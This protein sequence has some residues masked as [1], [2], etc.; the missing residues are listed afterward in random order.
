MVTLAEAVHNTRPA[1]LSSAGCLNQTVYPK[2]AVQHAGSLFT[3]VSVCVWAF[4]G[5]P[6]PDMH[7]AARQGG[8]ALW[9]PPRSA[10]V[11][12]GA[13]PT[14]RAG[15]S[16]RFNIPPLKA[17]LRRAPATPTRSSARS[18]RQPAGGSRSS[19]SVCSRS[20]G[21]PARATSRRKARGRRSTGRKVRQAGAPGGRCGWR[22]T[23]RKVR[24]QGSEGSDEATG[25]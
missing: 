5:L 18:S 16:L 8:D 25:S 23:G 6:W 4:H 10:P 1:A 13:E 19:V 15:L 21:S 12:R 14:E 7:V 9:T 2:A 3:H 24:F 22:G 20:G 17:R 11:K